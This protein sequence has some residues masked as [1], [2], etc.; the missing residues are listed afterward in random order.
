MAYE[1][2]RRKLAVSRYI[3]VHLTLHVKN[4]SN[5]VIEDVVWLKVEAVCNKLKL[6]Q[7]VVIIK[8]VCIVIYV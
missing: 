1:S 4:M 6:I 2:T 7:Y 8:F 5:K 3:S